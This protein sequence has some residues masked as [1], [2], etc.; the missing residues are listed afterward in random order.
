MAHLGESYYAGL[1]TAPSIRLHITG[2]R[3]SRLWWQRPEAYPLRS[4]TVSI[5][6]RKNAALI[7]TEPRNTPSGILKISTAEATALD[8][9]AIRSRCGPQ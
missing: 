2:R 1:L 3:C 7:P 9:S 4:E 8:L 5:M 6:V